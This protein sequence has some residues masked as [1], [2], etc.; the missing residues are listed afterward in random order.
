MLR[1]RLD[2]DAYRPDE[3]PVG[4]A[5]LLSVTLVLEEGARAEIVRALALYMIGFRVGLRDGL[6]ADADLPGDPLPGEPLPGEPLRFGDRVPCVGVPG[7][8]S[9]DRGGELSTSPP[10]LV[11]T[12]TLFD[13]FAITSAATRPPA[14]QKVQPRSAGA[15]HAQHA[16]KLPEG[17]IAKVV[18]S[19]RRFCL[20]VRA[21]LN[22]ISRMAGGDVFACPHGD[23][24]IL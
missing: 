4:E 20:D 1:A 3:L 9:G 15:T 16:K 24:P 7:E 19:C 23:V 17:Q 6:R 18:R 12:L 13:F 8:R 11:G 2:G 5:R 21:V 14:R 22:V 10:D